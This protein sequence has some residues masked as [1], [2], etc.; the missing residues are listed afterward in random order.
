MPDIQLLL[1]PS[2]ESVVSLDPCHPLTESDVYERGLHEDIGTRWME[3][4]RKLGFQKSVID[5][6]KSD[7]PSEKERCVDLLV[8]WMEKEGRDEATAGK[9]A[10]ALTEIGL[11]TLAEKLL[12]VCIQ[13]NSAFRMC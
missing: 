13:V 2:V 12:G 4:A 9:L 6:I 7:N 10:K 3:L 11:K 5:S 1:F 8:K